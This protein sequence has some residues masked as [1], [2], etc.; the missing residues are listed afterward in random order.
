MMVRFHPVPMGDKKMTRNILRGVLSRAVV[1]LPKLLT[2]S[3]E[4]QLVVF[5]YKN[6]SGKEERFEEVSK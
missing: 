5:V 6:G 1:L 3:D 2:R 4:R